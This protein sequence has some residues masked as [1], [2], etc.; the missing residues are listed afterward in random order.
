MRR[1]PSQSLESFSGPGFLGNREG[2]RAVDGG[3]RLEE[4]HGGGGGW[5]SRQGK[6]G[7]LEVVNGTG[8]GARG[9][10][11]LGNDSQN[12]GTVGRAKLLEWRTGDRGRGGRGGLG[13]WYGLAGTT[14]RSSGRKRSGGIG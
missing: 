10:N 13:G 12:L 14:E 6:D 11:G 1:R 9:G 4:R 7:R 3:S 2:S 5:V 8:V